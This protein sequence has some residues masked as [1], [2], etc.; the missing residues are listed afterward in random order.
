[1]ELLSPDTEIQPGQ[2]ITIKHSYEITG[3]KGQ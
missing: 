2:S 1:M 3:L